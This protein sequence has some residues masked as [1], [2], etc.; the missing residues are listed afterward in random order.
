M[1]DGLER[2][3][4]LDSINIDARDARWIE[5]RVA[6]VRR[7]G[8]APTIRR[9]FQGAPGSVATRGRLTWRPLRDLHPSARN[10][11]EIVSSGTLAH[12][13]RPGRV[14]FLQCKIIRYYEFGG[15]VGAFRDG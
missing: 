9:Q 12:N 7:A 6:T 4:S 3:A 1:I 14:E 13:K 15:S 11:E 10:D 2:E 8:Q 5:C